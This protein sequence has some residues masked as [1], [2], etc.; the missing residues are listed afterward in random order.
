V[1]FRSKLGLAPDVIEALASAEF[2]SERDAELSGVVEL[3]RD[4]AAALSGGPDYAILELVRLPSFRPNSRWIARVLGI[5]VDEVNVA[6]QRLLRLGLLEMSAP[7]RWVALCGDTTASVAGFAQA[8]I[9][10]LEAAACSL[11]TAAAASDAA[12]AIREHSSTT[13]AV[14]TRR[15]PEALACIAAFQK[16]LV[17]L[18]E[19]SD[20]RDDVYRLEVHFFPLTRL[21]AEKDRP[22]A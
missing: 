14:D 21:Q 16:E 10:R 19:R 8:A 11:S 20:A 9:E 17:E 22:D 1:L 4:V 13:L 7:D 3:A 5:E 15:L 2:A 18:L 6:L 12:R